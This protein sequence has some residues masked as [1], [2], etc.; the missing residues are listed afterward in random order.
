LKDVKRAGRLIAE[1]IS[2]LEA[3]FMQ[4]LSLEDESTDT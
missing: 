3:D 4:N 2:E 1:F